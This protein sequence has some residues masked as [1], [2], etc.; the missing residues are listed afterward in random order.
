MFSYSFWETTCNDPAVL[1]AAATAIITAILA[2]VAW[3]QLRDLARTSKADFI[4]RLKN[5]FF[6]DQARRLLFLVEEDLLQFEDS[7]IPYF[8]IPDAND[9]ELIGRFKEL[10]I[11]GSTVSTYLMDDIL[12]GPLEDVALFLS[13]K[14]ITVKHAREMFSTY[15]GL[16]ARNQAIQQYIKAIRRNP[17]DSDVY[18][19]LDSLHRRLG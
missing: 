4:F 18:A 11:E 16:C 19:G 3:V 12:L 10:G 1:W 14:L 13:E 8:S 17:D 15:V 6:T 7:P 5:D 2:G 9:P